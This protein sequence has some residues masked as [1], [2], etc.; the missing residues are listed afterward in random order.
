[1]WVVA[2]AEVQKNIGGQIPNGLFFWFGWLNKNGEEYGGITFPKKTYCPNNLVKD[3][4]LL[5]QEMVF[6]DGWDGG[7]INFKKAVELWLV[8]GPSS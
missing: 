5:S 4:K 8:T 2:T 7:L 1:M 6:L 3:L